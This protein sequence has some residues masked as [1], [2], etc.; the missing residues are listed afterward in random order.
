MCGFDLVDGQEPGG[1]G[2]VGHLCE[3]GLGAAGGV[4][5]SRALRLGGFPG[6]RGD[7]LSQFLDVVEVDV[8]AG[9]HQDPI[10]AS[11]GH[12]GQ[13]RQLGLTGGGVAVGGSAGGGDLGLGGSPAQVV[14]HGVGDANDGGLGECLLQHGMPLHGHELR[15]SLGGQRVHAGGGVSTVVRTR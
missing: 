12:G 15:R 1:A 3:Q 6:G 4:L 11:G 2:G 7:R 13:Q 5:G 14:R 9:Q 8:G 10:L